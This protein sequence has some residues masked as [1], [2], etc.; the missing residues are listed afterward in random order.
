MEIVLIEEE[1]EDTALR[2]L[3]RAHKIIFL[4]RGPEMNARIVQRIKGNKKNIKKS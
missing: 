4:S 2:D 3:N 1:N